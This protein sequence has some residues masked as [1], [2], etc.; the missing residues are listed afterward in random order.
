MSV[1][2]GPKPSGR[3]V[4]TPPFI[5]IEVLSPED[6]ADCMQVKIGDY[7]DFGVQYIWLLDP[8]SKTA[9]IY[10]STGITMVT[11]GVLRTSDPEIELPLSE[12]F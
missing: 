9:A 12:L 3:I 1:V 8:A 11:D 10:I 5:A 7:L 2:L 6:R 4:Q